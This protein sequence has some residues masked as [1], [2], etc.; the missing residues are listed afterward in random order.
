MIRAASITNA[1]PEPSSFAPGASWV[2]SITSETRLSIW[3]AIMMTWSQPIL[4]GLIASTLTIFTPFGMRGPDMLRSRYSVCRQPLHALAIFAN[5]L[6][7]HLRA[8]PMPRFG[9]VA[10]DNVWRVPKLTSFSTSAFSRSGFASFGGLAYAAMGD[11]KPIAIK[12][13]NAHSFFIIVPVLSRPAQEGVFSLQ[14][15]KSI[16]HFSA[17]CRRDVR[18]RQHPAW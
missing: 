10:D 17:T 6:C 11:A 2:K 4:P 9:S 8:A 14:Q 16:R 12:P 7:A 1:L 5:S 15:R 3:P 13:A 18:L